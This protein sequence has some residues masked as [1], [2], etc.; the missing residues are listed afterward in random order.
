MSLERLKQEVLSQAERQARAVLEEARKEEEKAFAEAREKA[1]KIVS[2]EEALGT[3]Q[4][5]ELSLEL[6]ASALLQAKRLESEAKEE[7]VQSVLREVKNELGEIAG[8][9]SRYE[10][11]FDSLA[12]QAIRALGDS[13]FVLKTNS[14]DRKLGAKYGRVAETIET[15]GGVIAAKADGSIQI[16]NTFEALLEENE[17]KIKQRA[18]E[19][20]FKESKARSFPSAAATT[21]AV[22]DERNAVKKAIKKKAI[23][24][25][26]KKRK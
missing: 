2:D 15:I 10:K 20:L 26:A 7:A 18:F 21:P 24:A 5:K 6:R 19:Q 14:R 3:A 11:I 22:K 16:N 25:K 4:A 8:Q 23:A 13:D 12:R 17:E 9:E 1:K